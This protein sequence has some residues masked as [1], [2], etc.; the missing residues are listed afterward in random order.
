M[1]PSAILVVALGNPLVADD[2][3][4]PAVLEALAPEALPGVRIVDGGTDVLTLPGT[5]QGEPDV[6]IV[7]AFRRGAPPGTVHRLDH[8]ALLALPQAHAG[9]HRLSLPESLRWLRLAYPELA[10]VRFR[11]WGIE[12]AS[13]DLRSELSAPVAAAVAV[14]AAEIRQAAARRG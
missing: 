11:L 6:W 7:D 8:D 5:W 3:A 13:L 1:T 2:G 9:A 12:P 10:A 14:V 4:G